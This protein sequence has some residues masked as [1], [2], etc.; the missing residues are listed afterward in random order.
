MSA[1]KS[2]GIFISFE[3][4]E[5]CGKTTQIRR[6]AERLE[7]INQPVLVTR[8]PGGTSL[9]EKIRRLLIE[10]GGGDPCPE[11]ELLLFGAS[12]AQLVREVIAPALAQGRLVLCDRFLDST[13]VYQGMARRLDLVMVEAVNHWATGSLQ[14]DLTL[15]LDLPVEESWA[16]LRR[17]NITGPDRLEGEE[18][19]FYTAVRQGYR[20][21]V[22]QWPQRMVLLQGAQP[23]DVVASQIWSLVQDRFLVE[24]ED[25]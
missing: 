8:E 2:R 14:P 24:R 5:G 1:I 16:R 22:D 11:A 21:L 4:G 15:V 9:G 23:E 10:D 19:N 7:K 18:A 25:R 12:R 13:T 17:R 3:G 20:L 6:L